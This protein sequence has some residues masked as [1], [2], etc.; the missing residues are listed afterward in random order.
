MGKQDVVQ[1]RVQKPPSA[2]ATRNRGKLPPSAAASC[3]PELV[4]LIGAETPDARRRD[5]GQ[6]VAE[7]DGGGAIEP[8]LPAARPLALVF[9]A[10]VRQAL[11]PAPLRPPADASSAALCCGRLGDL[12]SVLDAGPHGRGLFLR[13]R[14]AAA[15]A[16]ISRYSGELRNARTVRPL[17]RRPATLARP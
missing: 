3:S 4:A 14:G 15:G 8:D 7:R 16:F 9:A 11:F 1:G 13:D 6:T 12:Y 2:A 5:A 10:A 17:L